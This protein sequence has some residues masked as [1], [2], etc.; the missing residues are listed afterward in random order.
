MV[1]AGGEG[2]AAAPRYH[3]VAPNQKQGSATGQRVTKEAPAVVAGSAARTISVAGA[4][5]SGERAIL[6]RDD[7]PDESAVGRQGGFGIQ[8]S[9]IMRVL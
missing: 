5:Q 3:R 7:V 6:R 8:M 1:G 9:R 2:G 4:R